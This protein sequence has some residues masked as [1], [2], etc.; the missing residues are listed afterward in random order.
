MR[1]P[2]SQ[3]PMIIITEKRKL[4]FRNEEFEINFRAF[5]C[6]DTSE[7]FTTTELDNENCAQLYQAYASKHNYS[8][9]EEITTL[10]KQ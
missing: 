8:F 2:Y 6:I 9:P 4:F 7:Q 1:S 3:I 5:Q 10:I